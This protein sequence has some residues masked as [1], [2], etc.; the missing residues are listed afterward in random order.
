MSAIYRRNKRAR[1][2][3][4]Y[5]PSG[6]LN[7]RVLCLPSRGSNLVT[8]R[9]RAQHGR[10]HSTKFLRRCVDRASSRPK[11]ASSP[12]ALRSASTLYSVSARFIAVFIPVE[13]SPS[14]NGDISTTPP[15]RFVPRLE[16]VAGGQRNHRAHEARRERD[17]Q[18]DRNGHNRP[19]DG[20]GPAL[21]FG[22]ACII[23]YAT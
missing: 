16:V 11:E 8:P 13:F 18:I 3:G 23:V 2:S 14:I 4:I 12:I 17:R 20:A 6:A 9:T 5:L 1:D 22:D 21:S 7:F 10:L 19:R 15:P